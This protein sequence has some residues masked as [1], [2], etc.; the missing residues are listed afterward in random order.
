MS[1]VIIISF[2]FFNSINGVS[3]F[4]KDER[5][6]ITK[7]INNQRSALANGKMSN[8]PPA[9]DMNTL[10]YSTLFE[11]MAQSLARDCSMNNMGGGVSH[12]STD[13]IIQ[14]NDALFQE[15]VDAWAS[16]SKDVDSTTLKPNEN[17]KN[18]AQA[19]YSKNTQF[20]CG[21]AP[22]SG[23]TFLVCM[24]T[25]YGPAQTMNGPL[26]KQGETC[27]NCANNKCDKGS[28]LCIPK[29]IKLIID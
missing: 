5:N 27:G 3:S 20:G 23:K 6:S 16:E 12:Y 7:L 21:K 13:K 9:S 17:A 24:F 11:G 22:C 26:Y 25:P 10:T 2:L 29:V 28:G 15:A 8:L 18:F 1:L 19:F 4:G 14:T